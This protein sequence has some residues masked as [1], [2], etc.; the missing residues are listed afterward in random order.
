MDLTI[1]TAPSLRSI[2]KELVKQNKRIRHASEDDLI[3]FWIDAAD[4]YV[5]KET[6]RSLLTQTL[7]LRLR[8]VLPVIQLPRPPLAEITSISYTPEG[9]AT[10]VVDVDTE[11]ERWTQ[12]M[13]PTIH[14]PAIE[15]AY[16]EDCAAEGTMEI[17]YEAGWGAAEAVPTDIRLAS[18]QLASHWLTSRE[19]AFMDPRIMN[20]EKKIAFGVDQLLKN[21]RVPN[22]NTP[23]NGG[24]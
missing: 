17:V 7:T 19:A 20:V 9:E 15:V 8:A 5:E 12:D 2:T 13:L 23:I 22:T 14:I 16:G 3:D 10:I 11:I 1:T 24:W 21:H 4:R 18:L 6:N